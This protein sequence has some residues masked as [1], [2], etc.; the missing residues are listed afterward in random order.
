MIFWEDGPSTPANSA[1]KAA[2]GGTSPRQR[3]RERDGGR[4]RQRQVGEPPALQSTPPAL[5]R[6]MSL[7]RRKLQRETS[8]LA[9]REEKHE[10]RRK[11]KA[12]SVGMRRLVPHIL[13]LFH[14]VPFLP[15]KPGDREQTKLAG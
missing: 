10:R 5:I 13:F 15:P 9:G 2:Q 1:L 3:A 7:Q 11:G 4:G 8:N 14:S 6:N 12:S